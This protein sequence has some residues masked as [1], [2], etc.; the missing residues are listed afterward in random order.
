LRR[1]GKPDWETVPQAVREKIAA[2][3]GEPIRSAEIVWG[4]FG[5]SATFV[6]TGESGPKYFCKGTHPGQTA[7]GH[8]ALA[9]ERYN[10]EHFA[11]LEAFGPHYLGGVDDG[12]W[13]MAVLD[14]VPRAE[15][16]PPW[17]GDA[18]DRAIAL[19][20]R[21]HRAS[22]ERAER[23]LTPVQDL[24]GFNL[25]RVTEGWI[26]LAKIPEQQAQFASLFVDE[27]AARLWLLA[28]AGPLAGMEA[29]AETI[30]GLRS[31][32]HLDIRSDNLVFGADGSVKLV[33]WPILAF[34]PS[35]I[36]IAFFLPSLAGEGGPSC[37]EGLKLY[38]RETGKAFDPED[39]ALA[40][41]TVAGFFAARA[42][43]P[44]IP[45]LPRLRWVQK[46]QLFPALDWVC[47]VLGLE[48]LPLPRPYDGADA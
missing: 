14:Y 40:A 30:G 17:T 26:S 23:K 31:W 1:E 4:G 25:F 12:D 48:P 43:A 6:L 2:C 39:V 42:G 16:V 19:V 21:F 28:N 37:A 35:L 22:P 45:V 5:P 46:L 20:A 27:E 7:Q 36:D 41:V 8:A 24:A 18:A 32:L 9:R 10:Y 3:I 29:R 11:E 44:E 13:H 15:D 33:D 38:E 34:G 47:Q